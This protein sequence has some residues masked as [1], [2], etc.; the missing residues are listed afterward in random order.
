MTASN[1]Q[2]ATEW[3]IIE[4]FPRYQMAQDGTVYRQPKPRYPDDMNPAWRPVL[5]EWGEN[6]K[7]A[8]FASVVLLAPNGQRK[9]RGLAKLMRTVW[10]EVVE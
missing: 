7:G 5:V 9:R 8:K 3:R 2:S 4:G 1:T 6:G 10:P